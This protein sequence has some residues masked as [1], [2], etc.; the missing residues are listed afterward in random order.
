MISAVVDD[1]KVIL[2]TQAQFLD[3]D[4]TRAKC[5]DG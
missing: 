5:P 3:D 1:G 4:T 2:G